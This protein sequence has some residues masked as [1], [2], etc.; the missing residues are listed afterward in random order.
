MDLNPA[1]CNTVSNFEPCL[2]PGEM[3]K[4]KMSGLKSY[5]LSFK[6]LST[7]LIYAVNIRQY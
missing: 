5:N 2:L 7:G 1:Y 3:L 4:C 6:L